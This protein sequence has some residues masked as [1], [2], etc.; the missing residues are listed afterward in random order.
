MSPCRGQGSHAREFDVGGASGVACCGTYSDNLVSIQFNITRNSEM[1]VGVYA[2]RLTKQDD[3]SRAILEEC[4][5]ATV[6]I[7]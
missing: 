1:S 2:V 6:T 4:R 3:L 5:R 7:C